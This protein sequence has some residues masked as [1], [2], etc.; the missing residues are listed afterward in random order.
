MENRI[1][2]KIYRKQTTDD[3]TNKLKSLGNDTK[4]NKIGR[5]SCRERV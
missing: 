2:Y 1:I 5:A 4:F 3:I